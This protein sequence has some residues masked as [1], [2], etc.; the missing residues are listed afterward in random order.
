MTDSAEKLHYGYVNEALN[1]NA[2]KKAY[3]HKIVLLGLFLTILDLYLD[4][5]VKIFHALLVQITVTFN[6]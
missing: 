5:L 6:E 2:V 3:L 1:I 4:L